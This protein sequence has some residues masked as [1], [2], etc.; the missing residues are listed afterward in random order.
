MAVS[1]QVS[2]VSFSLGQSPNLFWSFMTQTFLKHPGQ[3]SCVL[4]SQ[5]SNQG[6]Y[7]KASFDHVTP[8]FKTIVIAISLPLLKVKLINMFSRHFIYFYVA[9]QL[10][11]QL[12]FPFS[13]SFNPSPFLQFQNLPSAHVLTYLLTLAQ[14][15]SSQNM[16]PFM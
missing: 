11:I 4:C 12:H 16:L 1:C 15:F 7:F 9:V 6:N 10:L 8:L 2:T 13:L 3:L 14:V 5:H